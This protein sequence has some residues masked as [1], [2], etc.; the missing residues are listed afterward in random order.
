MTS[1]GMVISLY[2]PLEGMMGDSM[3]VNNTGIYICDIASQIETQTIS[4]KQNQKKPVVA[5]GRID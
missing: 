5:K 4:N 1:T 3:F 2:G